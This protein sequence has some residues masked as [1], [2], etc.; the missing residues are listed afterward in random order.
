MDERQTTSR[1]VQHARSWQYVARD[2]AAFDDILSPDD[3]LQMLADDLLH[4][5]ADSVERALDRALHRGLERPTPAEE[6]SDASTAERLDGIDAIRDQLRAER[7]R[8]EQAMA[9]DA[10]LQALD[11]ELRDNDAGGTGRSLASNDL[12]AALR[13]NPDTARRIMSRLPLDARQRLQDALDDDV[14]TDAGEAEAMTGGAISAS[15]PGAFSG[16]LRDTVAALARVEEVESQV[17]RVRRVSDIDAVDLALLR[18]TLGDRPAEALRMLAASLQ[19]F[20]ASGYLQQ[21]GRHRQLSARAIRVLGEAILA[22]A[23]VR[24]GARSSGD[25]P[26]PDRSGS[27]ELTGSSRDHRFGDPLALDLGRTML[28]AI[29]RGSGLPVQLRPT[30]F[31]VLEREQTQRVATIL[32]IDLSRSMGERGYLLGARRLA[33]A[34]LA[35]VRQRYPRDILQVI[36]FS[37]TARRVQPQE[38]PSLTWDRYGVGTNVQEA[39]QF[40]RA[41]L[42]PHKGMQRRIILITDGEP[43]AHR[44][45]GGTLRFSQPPFPETLSVT[46]AEAQRLRRDGVDLTTVVLS[47][48]LHVVRFGQELARHADGDLLVTDPD[49]LDAAIIVR[50]GRRSTPGRG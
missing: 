13:A 9:D 41:L 25:R 40:A 37:E 31:A 12:L 43:T 32:A 48:S 15:S 45:P 38:L 3:L 33:L 22:Q 11:A 5:S 19:A 29:R 44:S 17:R 30:D 23:L 20:E 27:G 47:S 34:L 16:S 14:Q 28:R 36:G 18:A 49:D 24:A 46:Y 35:L 8:L 1:S 6:G 10:A 7:Q 21:V 4:A 50:Y 26:Q 42:V 39:L 2:A